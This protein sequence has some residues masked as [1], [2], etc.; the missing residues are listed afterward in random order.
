MTQ[1]PYYEVKETLLQAQ[2]VNLTLGG[3][4]I[5]RDVDIE[6]KNIHRPGLSQGQVTA[7][8][9]PSGMGKTQLLRILSGL[10]I[11]DSG[12]VTMGDGTPV[13]AGTVGVVAQNYPLL[14]HR[15]VLSNVMVAGKQAG[16]RGGELEEQSTELLRRFGLADHMDKYPGQLSGGQR[17]R[18]AIAQQF[19]CSDKVVFMDEPF[20]GL[21]PIA[22]DSVCDFI[23]EISLQDELRSLVVV[24]HDLESAI[25]VADTLWMLGRDSDAAGNKIAGARVVQSINLIEEGLAWRKGIESTPEFFD[26]TRRVKELFATL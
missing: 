2:G 23:H 4:L 9:G 8:L 24:T 21:D 22:V 13:R 19:A 25:R 5:L 11:P 18:V 15:K 3:R 16:L 12:T 7:L 6:I 20:S 26:M 14:P 1:A 17:Q 10:N